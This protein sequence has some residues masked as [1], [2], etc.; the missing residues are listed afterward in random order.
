MPSAI[1]V[2]DVQ[3]GFI[4]P[5]TAHIPAKIKSLLDH[6][7]FDHRIFTQFYNPVGS[8]YETLIHWTRLRSEEEVAIVAP[9][10]AYPTAVFKKPIYSCLNAEFLDYAQAHGIREFYLTGIDTDSCVLKCAV[11]LFEAGFKPMVLADCCMSH[12]GVAAHEAA[13]LILPRFIGAEQVIL[14]S[15]RHFGIQN[16]PG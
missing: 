15:W 12:G 9:L 7:A 6:V 8:P 13:L 11:D 3:N 1:L 10:Q 4:N 5:D 14:D 2:I 16:A